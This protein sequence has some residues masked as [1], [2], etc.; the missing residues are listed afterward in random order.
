MPIGCCRRGAGWNI[1]RHIFKTPNLRYVPNQLY[2]YLTITTFSQPTF[3][4]RESQLDPA[5]ALAV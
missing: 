4:S 2:L 3:W 1:I 5:Q